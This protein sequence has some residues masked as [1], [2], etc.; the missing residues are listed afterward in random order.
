MSSTASSGLFERQRVTRRD[1]MVFVERLT[2]AVVLLIVGIGTELYGGTVG[3]VVGVVILAATYTHMVELQHQC[4]HHSAF[5]TT[6]WHRIVGIPLGL[7]MLVSYSHYRV[8]HL[9]HHRFLGTPNDSEFFGFDTRQPITWGS[10][11]EGAFDYARLITVVREIGAA[12]V[13]RWQYTQGQIS[14]RR[15]KA[16][17]TEYRLMGALLLGLVVLCAFGGEPAIVQFWFMPLVVAA[18]IHF[19]VELPEHVLCE[20]DTQDVLRNTRSITGSKLTTWFTNGNNLHVE[21]HAAM[22]VPINRLRGRHAEVLR[23]ARHV[24][25]SYVGFYWRLATI[26][27]TNTVKN[28]SRSGVTTD[29]TTPGRTSGGT[30]QEAPKW[31]RY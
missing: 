12:T 18:P 20:S 6:R 13:G 14:P 16:V 29:H 11:L 30:R 17:I 25:R 2:V 22:T 21:H 31:L 28:L 27:T 1:E 19:M 4:L 15:R 5:R 9:Q 24:D 7:P 10:L 23:T 8:R 3:V 26:A